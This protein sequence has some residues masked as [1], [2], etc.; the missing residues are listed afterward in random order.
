MS[1]S[2]LGQ[3]GLGGGSGADTRSHQKMG[4]DLPSDWKGYVGVGKQEH[5]IGGP[6]MTTQSAMTG[7]KVGPQGRAPLRSAAGEICVEP[8]CSTRLS[9]YN[10]NATCFRHSPIRFP[11][12][13][14]RPTPV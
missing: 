3:I 4:L 10:R 13:R 9:I 14:G 2:F 1:S 5:Q 8:D 6:Q 11:R 12:T 7:R